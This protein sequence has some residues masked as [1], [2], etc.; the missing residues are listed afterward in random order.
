MRFWKK[1]RK[2]GI[3]VDD[4]KKAEMLEAYTCWLK[5]RR[6]SRKQKRLLK[7]I[8]NFP[9]LQPLK[10]L[11]DFSHYRF[12]ERENVIPPPGTQQR[13]RERVMAE[14]R[15]DILSSDGIPE[16]GYSP[17]GMGNET[18]EIMQVDASLP[19]ANALQQWETEQ[20][21]T[22]PEMLER[23]DAIRTLARLHMRFEQ[24]DDD[25]YVTDLGS[26]NAPY[27]DNE[28]VETSTRVE[29]GSILKCGKISF[30]VVNIERS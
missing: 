16:F 14:I 9:E 27:V 28:R 18:T 13:A 11:I 7:E 20:S 3:S 30:K 21:T 4:L 10:Q 24:K 2:A 15:G 29:D 5:N 22:S 25:V 17:Q 12:E 26:S 1:W 6:L 23:Y 19:N 8:N